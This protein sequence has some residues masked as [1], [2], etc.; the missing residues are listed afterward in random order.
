METSLRLIFAAVHLTWLIS[1]AILPTHLVTCHDDVTRNNQ[2]KG[3]HIKWKIKIKTV[4]RHLTPPVEFPEK[5]VLSVTQPGQ[6]PRD[7]DMAKVKDANDHVPVYLV[8]GLRLDKIETKTTKDR[9]FY[10]MGNVYI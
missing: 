10:S 5:L 8:D 2:E 7:L 4:G 9:A 3:Q 1:L 6:Q